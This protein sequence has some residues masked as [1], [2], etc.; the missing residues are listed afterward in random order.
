MSEPT[1]YSATVVWKG[2][3]ESDPRHHYIE[4]GEERVRGSSA[5]GS[6]GNP[7]SAN[8]ETMLV[9]ALSSCHMLWFVAY[10][11]AK[12]HPVASYV[13]EAVGIMEGGKFT[14]AT[15]RPRGEFE[16][17]HPGEDFVN[18]LHH[19]SHERCYIANSVNFPVTVESR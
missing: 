13:D 3:E 9:G 12:R 17:E 14:S 2:G 11:R 6:G 5:P 15:L 16:D 19:R 4:L 10:A 8:P 1:S 7:A 18:D